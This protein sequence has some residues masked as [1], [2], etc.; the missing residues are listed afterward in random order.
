[1]FEGAK[2][3]NQPIGGWDI[4]NVRNMGSMF[5]SAKSFNQPLHNW[6]IPK[7]VRTYNTFDE[8]PIKEEYKPII[9]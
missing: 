8:C 7:S 4:S 5:S 3:F 6:I 2:S 1:M 9:L